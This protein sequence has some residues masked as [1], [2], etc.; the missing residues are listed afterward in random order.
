MPNVDI[1][2][3]HS[4]AERPYFGLDVILD[5]LLAHP[6]REHVIVFR[7]VRSGLTVNDTRGTS[8]PR[9]RPLHIEVITDGVD[10]KETLAIL[11]RAYARRTGRSYM[12]PGDLFNSDG[13]GDGDD[14]PDAGQLEGQTTVDEHLDEVDPQV[15]VGDAL[16]DTDGSDP[17]A[18]PHF[19][20]SDQSQ[21]W[22]GDDG[23]EPGKR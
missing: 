15:A 8:T 9:I 21:L 11:E 19:S 1:S 2:A 14:G 10:K 16:A 22:P 17:T 23:Y 13:D 18:G 4:K 5:E 12:P 3:Q 20:D 6:L 7:A